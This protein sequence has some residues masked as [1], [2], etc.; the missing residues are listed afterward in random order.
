MSAIIVFGGCMSVGVSLS[1]DL[2]NWWFKHRHL[3]F[4]DCP[5]SILRSISNAAINS[6]S[7]LMAKSPYFFD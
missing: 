5:F 4:A 7:E 2:K 6:E 1:R 3:K